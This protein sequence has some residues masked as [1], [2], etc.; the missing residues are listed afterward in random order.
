MEREGIV[1]N[2]DDVL[3]SHLNEDTDWSLY[4]R[5]SPV[6]YEQY[7]TET[8]KRGIPL[9]DLSALE[10]ASIIRSW[11]WRE[12]LTCEPESIQEGGP[13]K[14][15][16]SPLVADAVFYAFEGDLKE[17]IRLL[18]KMS[19][20]ELECL[21]ELLDEYD[22]EDMESSGN[23]KTTLFSELVRIYM[24]KND[25]TILIFVMDV[26]RGRFFQSADKVII[27]NALNESIA[28]AKS[29]DVI[30]HILEVNFFIIPTL[31]PEYQVMLI[32]NLASVLYSINKTSSEKALAAFL[33][34]LSQSY[35]QGDITEG[36]LYDSLFGL[37]KN[38]LNIKR[39][40]FAETVKSRL[41][42]K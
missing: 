28:K 16:A 13:V 23:A 31:S 32:D 38:V 30:F 20:S 42:R 29:P 22:I 37:S 4:T 9:V 19:Q 10:I 5:S 2:F 25:M 11:D 18:D 15:S 33:T 21:F 41:F 39:V 35:Q 24:N 7:M 17:S 14:S 34:D 3:D 12:K 6:F 27:L 26:L 1:L 36:K 40:G 8:N